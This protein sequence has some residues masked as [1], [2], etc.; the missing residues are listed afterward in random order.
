M[1][2]GWFA[3]PILSGSGARSN[4]NMKMATCI[5]CNPCTSTA[6]MAQ[7]GGLQSPSL[8]LA[9]KEIQ[10]KTTTTTTT[11]RINK[12]AFESALFVP[13]SWLRFGGPYPYRALYID[14]QEQCSLAGGPYSERRLT[15]CLVVLGPILPWPVVPIE[16]LVLGGA[17][18]FL[19]G[20]GAY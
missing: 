20:Q 2:A 11:L 19:G 17:G 4:I 6:Y 8:P 14:L 12:Y 16:R 10:K 3:H 7:I 9:P 15:W 1:V 13:T 18:P 5:A